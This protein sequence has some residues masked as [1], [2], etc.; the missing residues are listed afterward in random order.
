MEREPSDTAAK[1][2][3]LNDQRDKTFVLSAQA[4]TM[5]TSEQNLL[6]A[7]NHE[8]ATHQQKV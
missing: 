2:D 8:D 4:E 6:P 1:H 5:C 3:T 7:A